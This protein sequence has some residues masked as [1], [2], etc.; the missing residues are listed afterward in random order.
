[1]LFR[2]ILA[3]Y[4]GSVQAK[5]ALNKAIQMVDS[6]SG[7]KLTVIHIVNLYPLAAGDILI[8]PS[9]ALSESALRQGEELLEEAKRYTEGL[10][11]VNTEMIQGNPSRVIPQQAAE[12]G[13]DLIVMGSRGLGPLQGAMLGSVSRSVVQHAKVP[14]LVFK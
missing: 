11:R 4:D 10:C 13:C 8:S 7:T 14:V 6:C 2:H 12:R 3:A 1:M 5:R 9:E